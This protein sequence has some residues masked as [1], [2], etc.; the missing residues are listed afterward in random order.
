MILGLADDLTGAL[1][2]GAKFAAAGIGVLVTTVPAVEPL[3]EVLV[4]DT[5][6][7]HREPA[8]AAA[9]VRA[10]VLAGR[11][12]GASL[13]YKKTDSTLRGNIGAEL[14]ALME[15]W[16]GA[17]LLYAA[18]YPRLGRTVRGGVL[19]VDGVPVAETAFARDPLNPIH[20][21]NIPCL[22]AP[23]CGADPGGPARGTR[24]SAGARRIRGGWRK[25]SG[26]RDCR[27]G[28]RASWAFSRR[29]PGCVGRVDRL[30]GGGAA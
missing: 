6:T 21:S 3:A 13:V 9:V 1:E 29:R 20:E 19:R 22:L 2:I 17:P 12:S 8:E 26:Y 10:L 16:P 5:E 14:G 15:A 18:A 27:A 7:R 23:F 11:R 28:R 24:G 25:R 4:V 30:P